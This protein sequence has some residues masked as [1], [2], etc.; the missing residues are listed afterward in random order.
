VGRITSPII[1]E[2]TSLPLTETEELKPAEESAQ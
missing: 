2:E 1:W